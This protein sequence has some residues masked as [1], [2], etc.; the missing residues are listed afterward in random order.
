MSPINSTEAKAHLSVRELKWAKE[1]RL[2]LEMEVTIPSPIPNL[3][4]SSQSLRHPYRH[5]Q[6]HLLWVPVYPQ[7][8]TQWL[9]PCQQ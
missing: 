8:Y 6:G 9:K 7:R 1:V 4:L 2:E 5:Q 3:K